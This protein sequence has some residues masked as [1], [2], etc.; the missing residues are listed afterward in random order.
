MKNFVKEV[1]IGAALAV[2]TFL[3]CLLMFY[4]IL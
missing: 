3:L 1:V 4:W 2:G